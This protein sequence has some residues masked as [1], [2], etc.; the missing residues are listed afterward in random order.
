MELRVGPAD[1][2]LVE[3]HPQARPVAEHVPELYR[4]ILDRLA[5]LETRG[6]RAEAAWIRRSAIATYGGAWNERSKR[7]LERLISRA[8]RVLTG[9]D[10]P[11]LSRPAPARRPLLV[12]L[13]R[14]TKPAS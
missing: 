12:R 7:A 1:P 13:L 3:P 14:S 11:R 10:R 9:H 6:H 4:A 8:D 5:D 2:S